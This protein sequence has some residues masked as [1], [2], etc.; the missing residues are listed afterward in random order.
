MSPIGP[1]NNPP[2]PLS[3]AVG[4]IVTDS[5]IEIGA[6]APGEQ[7][8]PE[9]MQWGLRKLN[10]LIDI[11]QAKE[12]YVYGEQFNVYTLIAALSPHTIGPSGVATFS[13]NGQP[14]PVRLDSAALLL[15]TATPTGLVDLPMNIRDKA[16]WAAQQTKAIQT[17]VPTDVYYDATNPDGS[18]F[19]W[20][21]PNSQQQ[22]RLG[23]WQTV[24]QYESILDPIGGPGG[25][26]TL[27]PAYRAA[28]MLTLA[29]MLAPGANKAI[30]AT[31]EKQALHA[32]AAVFGNNAKSPR[33]TT[34]DFGMP[35]S[36]RHRADFNWAT[37][38][39]V[40]GPPE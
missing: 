27:P 26:G 14:R 12:F 28:I 40:G 20:P 23:F 4:D 22:V 29:E 7:P 39:A 21:V 17:N 10:Y 3:Y 34:Q 16:W 38:G 11:W 32:R 8:S 15:N 6:C 24:S 33:I 2:A 1:P 13:T 5:F 37:G 36:G 9:E 25:P 30:P 19:F 18:L 35:K 31:L